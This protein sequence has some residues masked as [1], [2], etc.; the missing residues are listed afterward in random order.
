[1]RSLS[2]FLALLVALPC[3]AQCPGGVCP[4][5]PPRPRLS[6]NGVDR[7]SVLVQVQGGMGSGTCVSADGL[8]LTCAHVVGGNRSAVVTFPTGERFTSSVVAADATDDLAALA[9]DGRAPAATAVAEAEPGPGE[10]VW[11]VGYPRGAGPFVHQGPCEGERDTPRPVLRV[12]Y[13]VQ[14]GDSGGGVFDSRGRLVGVVWG[15]YGGDEGRH[16]NAV[17]L[18]CIRRFLGRLR[19]SPATPAPPAPPPP[20]TPGP[21]PPPP[22][23]S[24]LAA[25]VDALIASVEELKKIKAQPG[26][27]GDPGPAGP[28]GDKG[29]K[30]DPGPQG[31]VGPPGPVAELPQLADLQNR[32]AALEQA[33][34]NLG[35]AA[36][37]RV[38]VVPAD[39]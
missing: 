31:S 14:P 17:T 16:A 10:T 38:R 6:A 5:P 30:G 1:M 35:P 3:Q 21:M 8:V 22:A 19:G 4:S 25:K 2:V 20:A 29:D 13:G 15:Y 9:L 28:K 33:I 12:G 32:V 11:G 7:C 26:P 24:D 39:Q 27:K 36:K 34:K 23:A 37:Q 18:T